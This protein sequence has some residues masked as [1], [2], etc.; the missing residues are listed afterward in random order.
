VKPALH[1]KRAVL[2]DDAY[3]HEENENG[4]KSFELAS[5]GRAQNLADMDNDGR[6]PKF[7]SRWIPSAG[8]FV[9]YFS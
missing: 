8:W 5:V 6:T 7:S 9:I 2:E 1:V 3:E 4:G